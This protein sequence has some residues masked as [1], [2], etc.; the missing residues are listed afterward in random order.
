[1]TQPLRKAHKHIPTQQTIQPMLDWR[2]AEIWCYIWANN[3]EV[4]PVYEYFDR[5]GCWICPFGLEYRIFMLQFTH[6]K[7]FNTLV[8][9]GGTS[10]RTLRRAANRNEKPPCKMELNG[11]MVNTCDVYGHFYIDGAC[12]RCGAEGESL[13]TRQKSFAVR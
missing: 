1:M 13:I 4:N 5:A 10:N 6:P 11:Q 12:Y 9:V 8:R 3:L 7:L 2:T